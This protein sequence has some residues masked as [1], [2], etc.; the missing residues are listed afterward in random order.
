[1]FKQSL[2]VSNLSI[3]E[4]Q[5]SLEFQPKSPQEEAMPAGVVTCIWYFNLK[6]IDQI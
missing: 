2:Q 1:M 4:L 6:G 3:P 5:A